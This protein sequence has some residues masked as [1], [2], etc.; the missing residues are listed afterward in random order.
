M[1]GALFINPGKCTLCQSRYAVLDDNGVLDDGV[2][3]GTPFEMTAGF[4][5][6][7]QCAICQM[8]QVVDIWVEK[9]EKR[10]YGI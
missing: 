2:P 4:W 8:D 3:L 6:Y 1:S 7:T 10:E 9:N 5:I